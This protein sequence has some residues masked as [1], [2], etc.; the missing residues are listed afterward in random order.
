[1]AIPTDMATE[2]L[3][4]GTGGIGLA[5]REDL[6]NIIY[7]I[8]PTKTPFMSMAGKESVKA[9]FHEWNIDS[10]STAAVN[11]NISGDTYVLAAVTATTR[12]GNYCQISNKVFGI[13]DTQDMVDKAGKRSEMAYQTAKH[14]FELRRDM[15]FTCIGAD[16]VSL[17]G[18]ATNPR[19]TRAVRNWIST[20]DGNGDAGATGGQTIAATGAITNGDQRP[21]TVALL[22]TA[23]EACWTDG[24]EPSVVLVNAALKGTISGFLGATGLTQN[25]DAQMKGDIH[26]FNKVDV[27]VGD[28]FDVRIVPDRFTNAEDCLV[29]DMSMWAIGFLRPFHSVELAK[30]SDGHRRAIQAEWVLVSRNEEASANIADLDP[31]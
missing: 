18:D 3:L 6:S 28:F 20:D 1:M 31:A 8:S 4:G 24:G 5:N 12:P 30:I 9:T 14:G 16:Q 23:L 25:V 10:L 15:E 27:Y 29:L 11:T 13:T 7:N 19:A 21:L 26:L 17:P 2:Y 22:D